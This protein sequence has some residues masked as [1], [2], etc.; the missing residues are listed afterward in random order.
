MLNIKESKE[1]LN[2]DKQ[3]YLKKQQ[4]LN[5]SIDNVSCLNHNLSN[6]SINKTTR[7]DDYSV[8]N[9]INNNTL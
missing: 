7:D 5:S 6:K 4:R 3:L 1:S 9:N 2:N 8:N